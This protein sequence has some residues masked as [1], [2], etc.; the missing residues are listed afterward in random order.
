MRKL[1]D[2][3][4]DFIDKQLKQIVTSLEEESDNDIS[5][6]LISNSAYTKDQIRDF[7]NIIE[8]NNFKVED[9]LFAKMKEDAEDNDSRDY[10][11]AS[12][13]DYLK[14][15]GHD[16]GAVLKSFVDDNL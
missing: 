15:M 11:I 5:Q 16:I 7:Y 13:M 1:T 8:L 4:K 3:Q 6:H 10:L 14:Q 9:V 12:Q 2:D